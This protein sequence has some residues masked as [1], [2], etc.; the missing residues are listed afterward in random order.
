MAFKGSLKAS[1]AE[2]QPIPSI[3]YLFVYYDFYGT[4]SFKA[5]G[6]VY[7][8]LGIAFCTRGENK[9]RE[10]WKGQNRVKNRRRGRSPYAGADTEA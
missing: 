9:M 5:Q 1:G 10:C 6:T 7:G 8:K 3:N 2:N 4:F